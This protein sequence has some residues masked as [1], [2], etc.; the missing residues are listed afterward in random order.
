M[1]VTN[2]LQ[3]A[4]GKVCLAGTV[5]G[6][7]LNIGEAALHGGVLQKS[8]QAAYAVLN[9]HPP[10]DPLQLVSLVLMTFAQGMVMAWLYAVLRARLTSRV[11]T[12]ACAG[13]ICWLLSCMYAAVYISAGFPGILPHSLVWIPVA[14]QL[15]EY[16]LAAGVISLML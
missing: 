10:T 2:A 5:A 3:I 8:A 12:A 13:L 14:W 15:I 11:K 7:V 9:V 6:I 1:T 4:V 16:L